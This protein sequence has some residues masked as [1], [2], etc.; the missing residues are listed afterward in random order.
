MVTIQI[1]TD[2]E[3]KPIDA[4]YREITDKYSSDIADIVAAANDVWK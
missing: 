4:G 3:G 2:K 1:Y